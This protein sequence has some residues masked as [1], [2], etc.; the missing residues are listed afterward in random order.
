MNDTAVIDLLGLKSRP[1]VRW[2]ERLLAGLPV[3]AL[4]TFER[5]SGLNRQAVR[6]V[7]GIP[8]RTL[9]RLKGAGRA[10]AGGR[11]LPAAGSERLYGLARLTAL[12]TDLFEGDRAAAVEWL[13]TPAEAFGGE[14]PLSR[15]RTS[16]GARQVEDLIGRLEHGV[17]S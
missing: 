12:A 5:K 9:A 10:S 13:S 17:F 16:V 4:T 1:P 14:P 8:A 3:S 15:A 11:T 6:Q 2:H 7:V